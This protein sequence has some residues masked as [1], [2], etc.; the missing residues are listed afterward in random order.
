MVKIQKNSTRYK[1]Q[2]ETSAPL[3]IIKL[4]YTYSYISCLLNK[5]TRMTDVNL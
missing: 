5:L 1:Q 2:E 4:D 3:F